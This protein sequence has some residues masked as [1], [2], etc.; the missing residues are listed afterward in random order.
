MALGLLRAFNGAGVCVPDDVS[1]VGFD[2]QPESVYFSPP[3]TT[4]RQDVAEP[5]RRCMDIM[6]QEVEAGEG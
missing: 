1:V 4:V 5:G 2:D 6:L 3:L